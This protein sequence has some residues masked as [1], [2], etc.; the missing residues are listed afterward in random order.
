MFIARVHIGSKYMPGDRLPDDLPEETLNWLTAA[1]AIIERDEEPAGEAPAEAPAEA[2]QVPAE[3]EDA[4]VYDDD[5][6][7]PK[8]KGFFKKKYDDGENNVT[9]KVE[10]QVALTALT[11]PYRIKV[12]LQGFKNDENH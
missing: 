1:G 5:D 7:A 10:V 2:A 12:F 11:I 9:V 4:V 8:F 6:D 3:P